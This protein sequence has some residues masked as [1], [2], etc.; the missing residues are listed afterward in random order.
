V[1]HHAYPLFVHV[2]LLN[3]SDHVCGARALSA[4]PS[5]QTMVIV[6]NIIITTTTTTTTIITIVIIIII[7]VCI[8]ISGLPYSIFM[9]C[10][11]LSLSCM[12]FSCIPVPTWNSF[13]SSFQ[14]SLLPLSF[15]SL[16]PE[17]P[18]LIFPQDSLFYNFMSIHCPF[19]KGRKLAWKVNDFW[20]YV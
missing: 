16:L 14:Q 9:F 18:V 1:G 10:P 12:D 3:S 11:N 17:G 8:Q 20:L 6:I 5:P 13:L 19:S 15:L 4:K 2:G 7:K